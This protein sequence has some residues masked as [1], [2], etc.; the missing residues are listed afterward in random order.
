ME[1]ISQSTTSSAA[2]QWIFH[3]I[4]FPVNLVS[5][6][7]AILEFIARRK[8]SGFH[9]NVLHDGAILTDLATG[10]HGHRSLR[11]AKRFVK[12]C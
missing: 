10:E 5:A 1:S 2:N 9:F 11:A 4:A 6:V 8:F 7:K 3:S 12:F